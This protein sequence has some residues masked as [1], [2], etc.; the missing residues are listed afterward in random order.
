MYGFESSPDIFKAIITFIFK[1]GGDRRSGAGD[2]G[3]GGGGGSGGIGGG[4]VGG[5]SS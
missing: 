1:N 4:G 2:T 3:G 5:A